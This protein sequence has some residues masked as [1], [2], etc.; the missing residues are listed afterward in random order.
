M[1]FHIARQARDRYQFDLS[2]Y[3]YSGNAIFAN[4]HAVRLFVQKM[5]QHR[6]LLHY[7]EQAIR[8]G[9]IN[10]LGLIDEIFHH[11]MAV[12]RREINPAVFTRALL[13]LENK[14][15]PAELER[16]LTMFAQEFPP[17]AVYQGRTSI[18]EYLQGTT[19]G[20]S[21]RET[22]LEEMLLLWVTNRNPAC[23]PYLE[24]FDDSR[25]S[26]ETAYAR[27]LNQLQTF[28]AA[29]PS[30]GSDRLDLISFL[31]SPAVAV[32]YSLTGQLE[33]IRER[34]GEALGRFLYRLLS[35][36]DLIKEE[37]KVSF[38]GEAPTF[39]PVYDEAAL[40]DLEV[41][42]FSEDKEWMPRLVLIAKNT[43]VWLDQLSKQFKR[44]ISRLDQIP[45][46]ELA[47]LASRGFSGLWLIG[48]WERSRASAQVKQLCGNPDAIASAY[49]LYSYGIANGLGGESAY[50]NLRDRAWRFGIRLASDMVPNHMGIDSPWVIDHPDWFVQVNYSPYPAYS[51]NGPD[52]SD[53]SAVSIH[54]EDHYFDR[55][56]AAVVFKYYDH[57]DGSTRFI[58]H[59]NDGTTMPWNDTAQLNYLNPEVREAVIQTILS[60]ARRFPIIRF[61]AAMTLAKRHYQRLWYPEPGSGGDIPSRA[62]HGLT[63]EQFHE[64]F[65]TEFWREVVDRVAQESPDTL[66]LAEAFWLMEGYF[67]RSLGMHRVYNSAFMN[68][69]RNEENAK[70][71][72]LIKN[73]LEFDPDILKRYVNF[74]NNPD[75]RTAVDQF[76]K[77]DKYFGV[78]VLMATLPGLPMFGHGQLE[79][80]AEKYGM[81]FHKPLW[82]ERPD[83]YLV[84]RHRREISPL[85]HHR[86]LF[87][88]VEH[89]LLYDFYTPDGHVDENVLAYS[90]GVGADR[91]L[92]VVHNRFASTR[93]WVRMSASFV[94]KSPGGD[95]PMIQRS[96]G[97]GLAINGEDGWFTIVFDQATGLEHVFS[98]REIA[99][100]GLNLT[101][102]AYEYHVFMNI[103]QVQDDEYGS[104][105]QICNYLNGRGVP[106]ITEAMHELVM[107]PVLHPFREIAN[108]GFLQ[109]LLDHRARKAT[110]ELP[111]HLL[112]QVAEKYRRLLEGAA[113][114]TGLQADNV[115]LTK[116]LRGAVETALNLGG[117]AKKYP[118][119]G[120]KAYTASL[121][122]LAANLGSDAKKTWS[123]LLSWLF[124]R[125]TGK[126]ADAKQ[127]A[128]ISRSWIDEWYFNRVL[129]NTFRLLGSEE[130]ASH[131]Q[132]NLVKL[133]TEQ[134]N[135]FSL[136]SAKPLRQ[137]LAAWL[138]DE[139]IQRFIGVNRYRDVLWFNREAFEEFVWWMYLLAVFEALDS[140]NAGASLL[141]ERAL[142]GYEIAQKLL[143][144]AK[145]SGYQVAKLLG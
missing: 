65:P 33:F 103:R 71:R 85:L 70:Y 36:L 98:S 126:L 89:F 83:T 61:D 76:G 73:T 125:A 127:Y 8:A 7:P 119:P 66:L 13:E 130:A 108:P 111:G 52:L 92:V 120:S 87:A 3:S 54:I 45:D 123:T 18:E 104:H 57:R 11:V 20:I 22:V 97:Q 110:D 51:F 135:W 80:Y 74:M 116:E 144:A 140:P 9:Q 53:N 95:R 132:V 75:E 27:V 121:K 5:N 124:V 28:F 55:T 1:E 19:D 30:F 122:F 14:I 21:N 58:Y 94:V 128:G 81:E 134:Q 43:Y 96:L 40:A 6:D 77:G 49:S 129:E 35:T 12:Y 31:R 44:S 109:Y 41:E 101:L 91:A 137:L 78:C 50:Q 106:S 79:G 102:N 139:E 48:L 16:T 141:A 113:Q 23:Q 72:T 133:L 39:A 37:G 64:A 143:K 32:P 99:Q 117:L 114:M 118:L 86:A 131:R 88:G 69:L 62:E 107:Q 84:D 115:L 38:F 105:R 93:G 59:G 112:E 29:Q 25:L 17:L 15:G 90:N 42:A 145:T 10:A 24:L 46:E 47:D 136:E 2:L 56:D 142:I 34:W 60:V 82:D 67:V 63:K 68:M 4:F 100:N 138:A 26:A